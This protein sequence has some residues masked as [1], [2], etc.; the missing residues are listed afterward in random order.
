MNFVQQ[1]VPASF[2]KQVV[3]FVRAVTQMLRVFMVL[4]FRNF[5]G[6]DYA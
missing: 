3:I 5:R 6:Y 4:L 2:L 1:A